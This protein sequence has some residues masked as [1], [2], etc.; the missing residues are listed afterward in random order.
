M[1]FLLLM[2]IV[3][4]LSMSLLVV[5]VVFLFKSTVFTLLRWLIWW[6]YHDIIDDCYVCV[7]TIVWCG[8]YVSDL[9]KVTSV[10]YFAIRFNENTKTLFKITTKPY[11]SS[12]LWMDSD[13]STL[14]Y[15]KRVRRN[16]TTLERENKIWETWRRTTLKQFVTIAHIV[17]K[18]NISTSYTNILHVFVFLHLTY[19]NEQTLMQAH[20]V[21][22]WYNSHTHRVIKQRHY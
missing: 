16:H 17:L 4:G 8:W 2:S 1:Q 20:N 7:C 22:I 11:F 6:H 5:V 3:F 18:Y 13:T 15:E 9:Y 14:A 12:A 19:F 10:W 21:F